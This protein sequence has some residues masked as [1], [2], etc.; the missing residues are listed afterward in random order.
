M[1]RKTGE[2]FSRRV[3]GTPWGRSPGF[4]V[5]A[6]GPFHHPAC[7]N[8]VRTRTNNGPSQAENKTAERDS[9]SGFFFICSGQQ[10][11]A[12]AH[13]R[14]VDSGGVHEGEASRS[15]PGPIIGM[16]TAVAS[17]REKQAILLPVSSL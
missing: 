2:K 10:V 6:L 13:H 8:G 3:S 4:I 9:F 15:S 16:S 11:F 7:V 12:G 17:T 5:R 14:D 1:A